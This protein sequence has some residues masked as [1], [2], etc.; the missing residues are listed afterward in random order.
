MFAASFGLISEAGWARWTAIALVF[1]NAL[2]QFVSITSFPIAAALMILLDIVIVYQLTVHWNK[3]VHRQVGRPWRWRSRRHRCA[4]RGGRRGVVGDEAASSLAGEAR[5]RSAPG[6]VRGMDLH[7]GET[8][9]F[10][11]H[12]SWRAVLSFYIGGVAARS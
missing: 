7:P 2:I 6:T 1:V 5:S 12:P 9:V 10:E 4:T 8:I 11:G 3:T